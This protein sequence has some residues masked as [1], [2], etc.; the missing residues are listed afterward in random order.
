MFVLTSMQDASGICFHLEL[1]GEPLRLE[2]NL[3][4]PL[5]H[6]SQLKVLGK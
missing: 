5:R 3:T 1:V 6:V 4:C 2:L